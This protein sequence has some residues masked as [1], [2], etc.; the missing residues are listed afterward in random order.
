MSAGLI[1]AEPVWRILNTLV[2]FRERPPKRIITLFG[3]YGKSGWR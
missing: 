1:K 3:T 2:A